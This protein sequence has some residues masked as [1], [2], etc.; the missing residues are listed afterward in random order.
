MPESNRTSWVP[1]GGAWSHSPCADRDEHIVYQL[2]KN[3]VLPWLM[4]QTAFLQAT[5]SAVNDRCRS[6]I[7]GEQYP[8]LHGEIGPMSARP[9]WTAET[10]SREVSDMVT[11][12]AAG[13]LERRHVMIGYT[14]VLREHVYSDGDVRLPNAIVLGLPMRYDE[15]NAAPE[16]SAGEEVTRNY[17][18]LGGLTLALGRFLRESGYSAEVHHPR[19][20]ESAECEAMFIPHAV[21]AGM[22]DLGRHGS[23]ISRDF[24]PRVRLSM[25]TT[26]A[27]I[28]T[29]PERA[30]G[31]TEFCTWCTKCMDAC[32]VE[33]IAAH[34]IDLR[35]SYRHVVD[36][37]ACLPY[38]AQTDGCGICIA[39]CPY[40]RP[41]EAASHEFFDSVLEIDWVRQAMS[42]RSREGT[43]AMERYVEG[44]RQQRRQ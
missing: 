38:F 2:P 10:V 20:D 19:G 28:P 27:P 11:G 32:P 12:Y 39:V 26:D 43:Q 31:I 13:S 36:T 17:M 18:E 9:A 30:T 24:G 34:R 14:P 5:S 7:Y 29:P 6:V 23:M 41:D 8:Q 42:I 25:V 15:T 22:G 21:A 35:G 3:E 33:A 37:A 4:G 1:P 16:P 40:N 44:H